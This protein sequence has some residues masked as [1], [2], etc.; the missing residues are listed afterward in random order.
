M[1]KNYIIRQAIDAD[2]TTILAVIK[3]AFANED[4]SDKTEHFQVERLRNSGSYIPTLSIVA[5]C[6][7]KIV[8]HILLT[9]IYCCPIKTS[10]NINR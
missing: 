10:G 5:E 7:N 4:M 2:F 3:D 6:D 8:G 9:K 1:E